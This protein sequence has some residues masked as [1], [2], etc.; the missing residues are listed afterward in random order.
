MNATPYFHAEANGKAP[1]VPDLYIVDVW[2][3]LLEDVEFNVPKVSSVSQDSLINKD[4]CLASIATT[5][6]RH[7]EPSMMY[8]HMY[9]A[10][11]YQLMI[12]CIGN[13]DSDGVTYRVESIYDPGA[14]YSFDLKLNLTKLDSSQ[15]T[16]VS[17]VSVNLTIHIAMCIQ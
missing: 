8:V 15:R 17:F 12:R 10:L 7:L 9:S 3:E 6:V 2:F 1:Q 4:I 13:S 11:S 14:L 16:V 5:S